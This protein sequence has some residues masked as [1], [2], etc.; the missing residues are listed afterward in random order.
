VA[1]WW[2][3]PATA[4]RR[5]E[6]GHNLRFELNWL[7]AGVPFVSYTYVAVSGINAADN[8]GPGVGIARS[9]KEDTDLQVKIVGLAYDAME[10]GIYIDWLMDRSFVVPYPAG[11]GEGYLD[12]LFEIQDRYG[13]D[14]VIPSLDAELPLY[15][16]YA[17]RLAARG[18]RTFLPS[19]DQFRLRGKDRLDEI[20]Q[21]LDIQIP[22]TKAVASEE[23]LHDAIEEI[24]FPVMLKGVYYQAYT[25]R[26]MLEAAGHYR[27]LVS[28]WGYPIIVQ[29]MISGDE[30]NVVGI[31]DGEGNALG[32]VGVRKTSV[33]SLGKVWSAVTV[34]NVPMLTAAENFVEQFR[35][36]GPFELECIIS[37]G[38]MYLIEINPRFPAWVYFATGV[39][40][41]L[42]AR[43]LRSGLGQPVGPAPDYQAGKLFMRYT[44]ELVTDMSLFQT[45]MTRGETT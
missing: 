16:K 41:N 39:G 40:V 33:T 23:S 22:E 28:E 42:P 2:L 1:W 38:D 25:A 30:L 10:P 15:I 21:R 9:L 11:G 26:N 43:M 31:G 3:G 34:R 14:W 13:L 8:P 32:L 24:G 27:Q 36:R 7:H 4:D 5:Q 19:M 18:I 29:K 44:N 17:D 37:E 20:A 6:T 12:R 45:V 35:W